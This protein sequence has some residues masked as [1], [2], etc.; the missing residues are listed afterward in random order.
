MMNGRTIPGSSL[1]IHRSDMGV[2]VAVIEPSG[3]IER[4]VLALMGFK[5][6]LDPFEL[7]R[8]TVLAGLLAA[9]IVVP[10]TPGCSSEPSRVTFGEGRALLRGCY[11][12]L[13]ARMFSAA[14]QH[15]RRDKGQPVHLLGYSM[16][17]SIAASILVTTT[18]EQLPL[19]D[20]VLVEPVAIRRWPVTRLIK[21]V[22]KEEAGTHAYLADNDSWTDAVE[23]SGDV[24]G[25]PRPAT[26]VTSMLLEGNAIR[27]GRLPRDLALGLVRHE[28]A[29]TI[30][31]HGMDS[32]LSRPESCARLVQCLQQHGREVVDVPVPGGHPLWHSLDDVTRLAM[33]MRALWRLPA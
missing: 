1:R 28:S 31:V 3:P 23:P 32:L 27:A 13:A 8:L 26:H 5:A 11:D 4:D 21:G 17:A 33:T 16:G 29:A 6:W 25:G 19:H 20:I 12:P 9:R 2:A 24:P 10:E 14:R 30:I 15:L 22:R 7:Q 18:H